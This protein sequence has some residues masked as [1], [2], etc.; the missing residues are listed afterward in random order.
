MPCADDGHVLLT[1]DINLNTDLNVVHW[2]PASSADVINSSGHSGRFRQNGFDQIFVVQL[3]S[4][5]YIQYL[6]VLKYRLPE[7]TTKLHSF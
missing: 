3:A 1:T 2:V 6:Y 7:S 4:N 5:V